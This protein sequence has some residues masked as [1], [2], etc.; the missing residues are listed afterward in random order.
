MI[1][2]VLL[3][4]YALTVATLAPVLL[5]RYWPADRAPRLT[6]AL[7]QVL[8][9]SFLVAAA[10]TCLAF[11]M[12]GVNRLAELNPAIDACADQLPISDESPIS[13]V[14]GDLALAAIAF[15]VLR[16]AYSLL[17]TFGAA[18]L[19]RRSHAATLY[20]LAR[21]DP[22]LGVLV[23]DHPEPACYCLPGRRGAIVVTTGAL[24]LLTPPQ[25]AAVLQH[26]R[27]HLAARHHL[28]V[29]LTVAI[30][31][32]VPG[33]KLLRHA[34]RETRRLVE[35]IADDA[36]A[37]QSGAPT[38]AAALAVIG[39]GHLAGPGNLAAIPGS[40]SGSAA[41]RVAAERLRP[42]VL[43]IDSS[44]TVARVV[45]L[46]GARRVLHRRA[47]AISVLTAIAAVA[48][49]VTLG[50]V[51]MTSSFQPCPATPDGERPDQAI[52]TVVGR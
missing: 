40:A 15:L 32:T 19:R 46:I 3:G 8:S 49:P 41:E 11:A 33:V 31:R 10:T 37:R 22:A 51:S 50:L 26:E 36:A 29:A 14:L 28:V 23:L 52:N 38:V 42:G 30:R 39:V 9:C 16:L 21:P 18:R 25:L 1:A 45:R 12:A 20:M 47:K 4:L 6:L 34:E 35:L 24:D 13:A 2:A 44:P 5:D 17:D 43:G 27:A 7:L 48:V